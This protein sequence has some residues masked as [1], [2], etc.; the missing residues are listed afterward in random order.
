MQSKDEAEH[1][2]LLEQHKREV[3]RDKR[4]CD[5]SMKRESPSQ[6]G[7]TSHGPWYEKPRKTLRKRPSM[8]TTCSNHK[9]E[10]LEGQIGQGGHLNWRRMM[11]RGT[12]SAILSDKLLCLGSYL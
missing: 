5:G 8:V 3:W 2:N 6:S 4:A 12:I 7:G 11:M 9:N 1:T 10:P